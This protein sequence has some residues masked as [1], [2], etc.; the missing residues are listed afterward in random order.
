MTDKIEDYEEQSDIITLSDENG[1]DVEFEF[2]D[3]INLNDADYAVLL[4]TDENED[5]V[6]ILRVEDDGEFENYVS[7]DDVE[8][9]DAVFKIFKER[10]ADVFDFEC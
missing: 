3:L 8:I 4:P 9:L 7:V 2:L 5:E 10:F 1:N 6:V